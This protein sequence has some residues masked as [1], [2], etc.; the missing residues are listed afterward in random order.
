VEEEDG[1]GGNIVRQRALLF[2]V[3]GQ[4]TE[5]GGFSNSALREEGRGEAILLSGSVAAIYRPP[6]PSPW[7]G[8][9]S[10]PRFPP[11]MRLHGE[12]KRAR[13]LAT[14]STRASDP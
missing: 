5:E 9:A 13:S 14:P 1:S 8:P 11:S 4:R 12:R 7:A 3:G 2:G 10:F 6:P